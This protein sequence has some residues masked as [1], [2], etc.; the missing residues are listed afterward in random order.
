MISVVTD[1]EINETFMSL[2]PNKASRPDGYNLDVSKNLGPLL[3]MKS[4]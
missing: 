1:E 3:V 4:P 2:N